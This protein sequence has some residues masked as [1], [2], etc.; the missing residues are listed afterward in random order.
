[1]ADV[2]KL[3]PIILKWEGLDANDPMDKGGATRMGVTIPTWKQC[4][5]DKDGDGDIDVQDLRLIDKKDVIYRILK[6]HYWD[7]FKAD[8]IKNQS[9]ANIL[10]DWVWGSGKWAI[11]HT[12]CLLGLYVDGIVGNKTIDAINNSNQEVLFKQIFAD[13]FAFINSI[14][15]NSVNKYLEQNPKAKASEI[16]AN[17]QKKFQLGWMN[18]LNDYKYYKN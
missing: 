8:L 15:T 14:V 12:Q 10:V 11:T 16:L 1:M 6:P 18:R 17:T 9:I 7:R 2:L 5:Y 13:R 3:A 4:G